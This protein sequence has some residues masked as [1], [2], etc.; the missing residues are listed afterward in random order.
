MQHVAIIMP[1]PLYAQS[2]FCF[3]DI[4]DWNSSINHCLIAFGLYQ[5]IEIYNH[6]FIYRLCRT[7]AHCYGQQEMYN[8]A[9]PY[10]E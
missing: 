6:P 4:E 3:C 1:H 9:I 5:S 2:G 7:I 8:S 10:F